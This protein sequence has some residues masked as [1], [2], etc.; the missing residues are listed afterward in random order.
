MTS[1]PEVKGIFALSE[2]QHNTMVYAANE[3][4]AV[5][6]ALETAPTDSEKMRA[7]LETSMKELRELAGAGL[8]EDVSGK[9]SESITVSRMNNNRGFVVFALTPEAILM[10]RE[11]EKKRLV[12]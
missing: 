9:F 2:K 11:G 7:E 6:A 8:L 4:S 10:F 12:N 3:G 5:F 1:A